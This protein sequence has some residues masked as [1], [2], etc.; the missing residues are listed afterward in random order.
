MVG[1]NIV[2]DDV[3]GNYRLTDQQVIRILDDHNFPW[4]WGENGGISVGGG[5]F[6]RKRTFKSTTVGRIKDYLGY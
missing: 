5:V 3:S 2:A 4:K 6:G 1:A